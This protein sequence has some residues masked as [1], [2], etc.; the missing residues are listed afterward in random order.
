MVHMFHEVPTIGF[1]PEAGEPLTDVD[2]G[3]VELMEPME[4]ISEL[5]ELMPVL[6]SGLALVLGL[7]L[8]V[9]LLELELAEALGHIS[10]LALL[11]Q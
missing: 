6:I 9:E 3:I 11:M 2:I 8:I 10:E 1:A 7:E 5:F 4:P